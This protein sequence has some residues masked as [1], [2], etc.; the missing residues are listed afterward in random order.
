LGKV[1]LEFA[2][3]HPKN[4][5]DMTTGGSTSVRNSWDTLRKAGATA[6]EMLISAAAQIWNVDRASCRAEKGTVIHTSNDR[7]LNYGQLVEAA[8]KLP[9]P[10]EVPLKDAK[11]FRLLGKNIPRLDTPEKVYGSA[12]FGSDM[13]VPGML[14][15]TVEHSP[16]FGGKIKSFD[17]KKALAIK[18]VRKV[19]EIPSG[20][21]VVA[22]S[23]YSATRG[24]EVLSVVWDEGPNAELSSES[25]HKVFEEKSKEEGKAIRNEGDINTALANAVKK[26]EATYEV[27]FLA[28]APMEPMNCLADVRADGA[29]IWAPTQAPQWAQGAVAEAVKLPPEKIKVHTTLFGGGFGR[30]LMPDFAVEAAHISKAAGAPVKLVWTREDDMRHDFYRPASYH[31]LSAGVDANGKLIAWKHHLVAPSISAQLFGGGDPNRPDAVDGAAQLPYQI[32]N[33]SV[34]YVMANTAVPIGWWRS[35]YHSQHA[36]VNESFLDE[37]A[38]A[39]GVD[40]YELR[41]RLLPEGSRLRKV[42]ELVA[43]KAY[44]NQPPAQ[45]R[46]RGIA[47]HNCFGSYFAHVAEVSVDAAGKVRVHK[48]VCALDCG[49]IVHP[50]IIHSQVESA[51]VIG[52]SAALKGEITLAKGHVEQSNFDDY[53][54]LTFDEMPEV[55]V[56]IVPSTEKQGGI[57]E[58]GLPPVAPAVCNAIFAATGKRIRRLPIQPE[59]LKKS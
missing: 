22:D 1:R 15:A 4:Y 31:R 2:L 42:L 35:V 5:G 17:D 57:G 59:E 27:P 32:P 38:V 14:I 44:W 13:K 46:S 48:I 11:D 53:P 21:A 28:H 49:P 45:G 43:E 10:T 56:H 3:A 40:P 6:R 26:I 29:E 20:V 39:A 33:L 24:R 23:T 30:R 12:I 52:L 18:G 25:I 34:D 51:V 37:I 36:F 41:R 50:G 8:A 55:E 58:P 7:R 19:V 54:L 16:V 9:V 47:C